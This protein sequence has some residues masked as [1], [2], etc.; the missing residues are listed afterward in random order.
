MLGFKRVEKGKVD[1]RGGRGI[2]RSSAAASS[3]RLTVRDEQR[4]AFQ[5]VAET[6]LG[7][8]IRRIDR[9]EADHGQTTEFRLETRQNAFGRDMV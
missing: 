8:V 3:V 1:P 6:A 5:S 4:I 2:E 7:F 9:V